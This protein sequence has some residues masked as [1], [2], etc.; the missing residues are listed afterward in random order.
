MLSFIFLLTVVL[1]VFLIVSAA[2]KE[3]PNISS[4]PAFMLF[5]LA[6]WVFLLIVVLLTWIV[7]LFL[8]GRG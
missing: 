4:S 2:R 3:R 6:T 8:T 5:E 1:L 7:V